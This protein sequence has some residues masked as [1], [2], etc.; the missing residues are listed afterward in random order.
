MVL[1]AVDIGCGRTLPLTSRPLPTQVAMT[2]VSESSGQ[3]HGHRSLSLIAYRTRL[4]GM[5]NPQWRTPS[6]KGTR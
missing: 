3:V 5:E 2:V 6:T 1:G 4:F